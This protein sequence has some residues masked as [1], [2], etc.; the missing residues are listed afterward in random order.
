MDDLIRMV[1][2]RAGISPDQAKLAVNVMM[3]FVKGKMPLIGDQLKGLL[4]GGGDGGNPLGEV[5]N[6]IGGM[7]GR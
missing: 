2:E 1:S 6:K 4:T 3:E 5:M 7:F